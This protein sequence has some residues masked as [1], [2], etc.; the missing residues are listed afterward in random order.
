MDKETLARE[1]RALVT[2]GLETMGVE[3]A[4]VVIVQDGEVLL[5]DGYGLADKEKQVPMT[6]DT[7]L[8]IASSSKAFTAT[9]AAM[10]VDDGKLDLDKPVRDYLPEFGLYDPIAS[11]S[12]TT[13]DLLCHRTGMPRHDLMWITQPDFD[14]NDIIFHRLRH[15]PPSKPFRS[16]WQYQNFMYSAAG[17]VVERL[18]GM[19]WEEFV[20]ARI[21]GPLEMNASSFGQDARNPALTYATLYKDNDEGKNEVCEAESVACVGPAGSIRST[22]RDVGQ[23]LKFNLAKGKYGDQVLLSEANHAELFKPN[24][25]YQLFPFS[26]D[27]ILQI[28]YGMGWFIDSFRGERRVEHGGNVSGAT[29]LIS[30][31]PDK[32]IGCAVISN[33]DG[34]TLTYALVYA[35]YDLL[36]GRSG[37]KD[38]IKFYHEKRVELKAQ[39]KKAFDD[40]YNSKVPNKP[41]LHELSE[42]CGVYNH[43]AY[44][45][46]SV[47]VDEGAECD[48]KLTLE[49]HGVKYPFIH[50]HYDIFY[51]TLQGIP[52]PASFRTGVKGDVESLSIQM[53]P[54]LEEYIVFKHQKPA[55]A[56]KGETHEN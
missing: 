30:M 38:W 6:G 20:R 18:S 49:I 24:I 50:L 8:P 11:N 12:A 37:E 13:R 28:G 10:T 35:I 39:G 4:A 3:G 16:V 26:V 47:G 19:S 2:Q 27:E 36:L 1:V 7:V 55:E 25:P 14:R 21:F 29:T 53:E 54:S 15:L 9:C 52:L 23:W 43:P 41:L 32:N 17:C 51:M 45:D 48:R 56:P 5:C 46:V 40:F 34:A 33:A 31:L 44:G 42:Y 22:A